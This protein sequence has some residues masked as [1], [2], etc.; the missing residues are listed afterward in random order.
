MV[1]FSRNLKSKYASCI[2]VV[3]LVWL[4]WHGEH[5]RSVL[6]QSLEELQMM[7]AK[8]QGLNSF[9]DDCDKVYQ[10]LRQESTHFVTEHKRLREEE[11]KIVDE[12]QKCQDEKY[13]ETTELTTST[14]TTFLV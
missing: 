7:R 11:I 9:I 14:N 2:L 13:P 1:D 3:G 6:A 8:M 10:E 4:V 5:E 12:Y